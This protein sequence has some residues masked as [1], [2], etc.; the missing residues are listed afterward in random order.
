MRK[1][2]WQ[3]TVLGSLMLSHGL[4]IILIVALFGYGVEPDSWLL[5]LVIVIATLLALSH[6]FILKKSLM[7]IRGRTQAIASGTPIQK[8]ETKIPSAYKMLSAELDKVAEKIDE[9]KSRSEAE[10]DVI[11]AEAN[12]LRMILNSIK[13]GVFALDSNKHII[14]FNKAASDITGLSIESVA[15]K[16]INDVLPLAH[17]KQLMLSEWIDECYKLGADMKQ[18][19]WE[20]LNYVQSEDYPLSLDVD[21]LYTGADP[22]GVRVLVTFHNRTE[23]QQI[24]DM[25]LDFVALAAHELRTPVTVIKGYIEILENELSDQLEPE[26]K[27]FIRKLDVS[28]GQLAG[29]INNILH[30]SHIEH[31]ELN[32]DLETVSWPD[33]VGSVA[34]ELNQKAQTQNKA[35]VTKIEDN[36]PN[37]AADRVSITEV[38]TNLIDNAIKYSESGQSIEIDV[39]HD[40]QYRTVKTAVR[41]HGVGM[42]SNAIGKLFTKF[43][44]SHRTRTSHRGTGLGLY[45]SKTIVEAHGGSIQV[46]SKEGEGSTFTFELPT[47][48]KQADDDDNEDIARGV[49]GWIKNHSLYRG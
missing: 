33:I 26:Y 36:I 31:G 11:H 45:M 44:R 13:D 20:G 6:Y 46:E 3:S 37:V 39:W 30:V 18:Q 16:H 27:E 34:A 21:A 19:Q 1:D 24:E 8:T 12:R 23:E 15:G 17:N 2:L 10:T 28:A 7:K 48:A 40:Q 32:L 42:P 4:P 49:H 41:D 22:N 14:L 43:Y 5:A 35:I 38:L 47:V 29:S 25:K 9:L